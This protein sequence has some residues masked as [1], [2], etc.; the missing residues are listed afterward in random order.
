MKTNQSTPRTSGELLDDL[1]LLVADTKTMIAQS[2]ADHSESALAA[3]GDRYEAAQQRF[4]ELY[5]GA[6]EK[7]VAGAK[8][9][10]ASIRDHPYKALAIALGAGV[11]IGALFVRP[12]RQ[13]GE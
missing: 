1:R 6:R 2:V 7:V 3:L 5:N 8:C 12:S 10:D 9:T 13:R 4:T 11:L